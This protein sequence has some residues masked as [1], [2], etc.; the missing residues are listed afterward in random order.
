MRV[1]IAKWGNSAGVRIPAALMTSAKL[2]L[3]VEAEMDVE[4]GKLVIRPIVPVHE[5]SLDDLVSGITPENR[6][7]EVSFGASVGKEVL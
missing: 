6:H 1:T 4:A 2:A 7:E 5:Y 3:G